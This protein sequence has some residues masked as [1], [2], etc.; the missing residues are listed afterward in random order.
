VVWN[1][2]GDPEL[3]G[4]LKPVYSPQPQES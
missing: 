4:A 2:G 3:I 1:K